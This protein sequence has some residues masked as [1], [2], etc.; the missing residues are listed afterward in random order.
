[1][2][3]GFFSEMKQELTGRFR[4]AA[5]W[6][7]FLVSV[8]WGRVSHAD[9]WHS[10]RHRPMWNVVWSE[11]RWKG[12]KEFGVY[13]FKYL[14]FGTSGQWSGTQVAMGFHNLRP[15]SSKS[16]ISTRDISFLSTSQSSWTRRRLTNPLLPTPITNKTHENKIHAKN[17]K[18]LFFNQKKK[19]KSCQT[20]RLM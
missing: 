18:A 13:I 7:V 14:K 4:L 6:R 3:T 17:Q 20:I 11:N 15:W 9:Q 10:K 16:M 5:W 1:M 8:L 2:G 19:F 12:K